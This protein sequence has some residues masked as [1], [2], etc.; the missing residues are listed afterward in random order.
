MPGWLKWHGRGQHAAPDADAQNDGAPAFEA[1][2]LVDEQTCEAC[3]AIDGKT[4]VSARF[5]RW[6][7]DT[8]SATPRVGSGTHARRSFP[9]SGGPQG[10]R[11][12]SACVLRPPHAP[13][14]WWSG[15]RFNPACHVGGRKRTRSAATHSGE[16][17][18]DVRPGGATGRAAIAISR[19]RTGR[20]R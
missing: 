15:E 10:G 12:P 1:S 6:A 11:D 14:P 18:G 2:E 20:A 9:G 13:L 16:P 5:L 8:Q 7:T 19:P 4:V 17:V 3:P